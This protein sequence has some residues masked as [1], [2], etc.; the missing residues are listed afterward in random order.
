M[1][2]PPTLRAELLRRYLRCFGP[3]TPN[4]FASWV[5]VHR[6][7]AARAWNALAGSLV[8][9]DAAGRRAW[10][11][12]DDADALQRARR[13]EGVRLLPPYDAYLD[14]RDRSTLV[15]DTALHSRIWASLGNAGAVLVAGEIAGVWRPQ[16]KGTRLTIAVE[17]FGTLTPDVRDEIR[18]EATA[19]GRV[20]GCISVDVRY[21]D[22]A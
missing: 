13:P 19:L 5:G 21:A 8:Q 4:D 16:K 10:V 18:V 2:D 20:R 17:S 3:T 12:A 14:Q 11:H 1:G 22:T 15:P 6:D 9:V 7:E